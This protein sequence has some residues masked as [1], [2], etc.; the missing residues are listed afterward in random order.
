MVVSKSYRI[1]NLIEFKINLKKRLFWK[2]FLKTFQQFETYLPL[3][4]FYKFDCLKPKLLD[5]LKLQTSE[6]TPFIF[7]LMLG[8]ASCMLHATGLW[9]NGK[10]YIISGDSGAGK[11]TATF[12][13]MARDYKL[14]G[15]NW[16]ILKDHC[17]FSMF[18]PLNIFYYNQEY[19]NNELSLWDKTFLLATRIFYHLTGKKYFTS[20][21]PEELF[22]GRMMDSC[23]CDK[24]FHL[25]KGDKF[26]VQKVKM[27]EMTKLLVDNCDREIALPSVDNIFHFWYDFRDL[28]AKNLKG[29]EMYKV[30]IPKDFND[31]VFEQLEEY[32]K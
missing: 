12:H 9:K 21:R 8:K 22:N 14:L 29:K 16:I 5:F 19:I 26:K 2:R 3:T 17:I 15:D 4:Q 24:V 20:K 23:K 6:I 31:E 1:H 28:L 13:A 7:Y 32:M 25:V 11:T 10:G 18:Y 30:T 27:G